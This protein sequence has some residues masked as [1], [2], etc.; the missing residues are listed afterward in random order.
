V[1][2][3]VVTSVSEQLGET[4][5]TAGLYRKDFRVRQSSGKLTAPVLASLPRIKTATILFLGGVIVS[6]VSAC[7]AWQT[8]VNTLDQVA[9]IDD[10]RYSQLLT[11]LSAAIDQGDSVPSQGVPSSGTATTSATGILAFTFTQPFDFGH[12]TKTFTPTA[13][14]NWQNNWTITPI[15]DPQD[16]QNLRALYGLVYRN[17]YEVAEIILNTL[18][19]YSGEPI[20]WDQLAAQAKSKCGISA[21]DPAKHIPPGIIDPGK[22]MKAYLEALKAF[23]ATFPTK[24]STDSTDKKNDKEMKKATS[25]VSTN[26]TSE[27]FYNWDVS[28]FSIASGYLAKQYGLLYPNKDDV[29]S[30]LRNGLSPECRR[31]QIESLKSTFPNGD[32][33]FR[34]DAL[35]ARSLFWKDSSGGWQPRYGPPAG[36]LMDHIGKYG[37]RDFWTTSHACLADLV[38]L[39]INS[40]ANSHAAAQNNQKGGPTPALAGQ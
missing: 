6:M 22:A 5:T 24:N 9:T 1:S 15:S 23:P 13:M 25:T 7:T 19:E 26:E 40:T 28:F 27:C 32:I 34:S 10:I 12:N 17:D 37:N 8:Q 31:Y 36:Y 14:L 39:A 33:V 11:N 3:A 20:K 18:K 35:F 30:S 21:G 4:T 16:L 38:V 2:K 29:F